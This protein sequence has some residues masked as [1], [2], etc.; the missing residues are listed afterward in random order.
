MHK[1]SPKSLV[2][3][4]IPIP[5]TTAKDRLNLVLNISHEH[6]GDQPFGLNLVY[7]KM[8]DSYEQV[9]TRRVQIG[10][11]WELVDLGWLEESGASLVVIENLE[12]KGLIVNPTPDQK[13]TIESKVL[14]VAYNQNS[15][16][17][18][19]VPAMGFCV[20]TP[21]APLYIRC[22]KGK[23]WYRVTCI[24]K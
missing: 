5:A 19:Y 24:P 10:K 9:Y 13:E 4:A 20:R 16:E 11:G 15:K 1:I 22:Q 12:G 18:D 8:L 3:R 17:S 2:A 6:F 21:S 14:E 23:A 7:S